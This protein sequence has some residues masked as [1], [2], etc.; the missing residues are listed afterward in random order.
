MTRMTITQAR[1]LMQTHGVSALPNGFAIAFPDVQFTLPTVDPWARI[2]IKLAGR[3]QRGLG[4]GKKK[5]VAFGVFCIEIF[6]VQG[7]GL[8]ASDGLADAA[9][10]KLES[11]PSS[12]ITY[13][14][15]RAVDIG[16]DG[17]FTKTNIYAEFEY[18]DHH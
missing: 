18:E 4:D 8:T 13:R 5:Y 7:D 17:G 12:L 6:T 2:T 15:I 1:E 10:L 9:V 11:L 3:S 14:N 16:P